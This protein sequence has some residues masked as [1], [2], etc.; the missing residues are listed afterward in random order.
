VTVLTEADV[1][2][3]A[4]FKGQD[5]PVT[6]LYL[7]VDGAR[8]VRRQDLLHELETLVRS[9]QRDHASNHSVCRDLKRIEDHVRGGI[10]RS[11]VR[12]LA[13]FS[14]SAHDFWRV[15]E[16]PVPVRSQVVVN[17]TP[18]VRQ[19]ETI[20]DEYERFG[21][22]LADKQRTR[23]MVYELGQLVDADERFDQLPRQEDVGRAVRKDGVRDHVQEMAHQHLRRAA[24]VAFQMLQADGFD[25]LII[26]A[27]PEIG[28]ELESLLHP[29][30]KER[31]VAR[32]NIRSDASL[33]EVRQAALEVE[34]DVERKKEAELVARLRD[35]VGASN[36]GV[37]GLDAT[38]QALV[39]RRVDVL[40]VSSGYATPGWRCGGCGHIARI[41][42]TC[43][44]CSAEM[45]EVDDVVEEAIEEALAQSCT[46]EVCIGNADLDVLGQ[47]GALLRY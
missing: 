30:L 6:S 34:A 39:E 40:L 43:A 42:R 20:V 12:G 25:R 23:M 28:N 17:H 3:L 38:L 24:D 10:D 31:L 29:Y 44:L 46:V 16:L 26:G 19:L 22:L 21:V 35:A 9:V 1:R 7:D 47:I 15:V 37:A 27:P 5:A 18:A 11:N 8:H 13:M 36:R 2:E 33:D 4:G 45:H 41:G 14:C 32:C